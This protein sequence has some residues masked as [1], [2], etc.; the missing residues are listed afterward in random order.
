MSFSAKSCKVAKLFVNSFETQVDAMLEGAEYV[1]AGQDMIAEHRDLT[2]TVA[3]AARIE[4]E[5]GAEFTKS[6]VLQ[7][8]KGEAMF[9][10]ANKFKSISDKDGKAISDT[11]GK[12]VF[13]QLFERRT[14]TAI[15]PEAVGDVLALLEQHGVDTAPF[16]TKSKA[17]VAKKDF[18]E[19]RFELR[20]ELSDEVNENVDL[21]VRKFAA[22]PS[23]KLNQG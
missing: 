6:I 12:R 21:I 11:L 13:N 7:G 4:A 15:R 14:V 9:V 17:V 23:L 16:V 1:Q 18:R 2:E 5:Q 3:D 8:T 20:S 10:F 19:R 22:K